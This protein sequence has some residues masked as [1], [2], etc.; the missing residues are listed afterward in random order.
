LPGLWPRLTARLAR[1]DAAENKTGFGEFMPAQ[2]LMIQ[3]DRIK[4]SEMRR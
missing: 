2:L 1:W 3:Q 4:L